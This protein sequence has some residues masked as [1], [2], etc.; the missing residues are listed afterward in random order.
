ML[1]SILAGLSGLGLAAL[2]CL[3]LERLR[4]KQ[5]GEVVSDASNFCTC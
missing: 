5:C 1:P 2:F 4:C 3:Q